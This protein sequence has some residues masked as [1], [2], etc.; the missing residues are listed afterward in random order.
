MFMGSLGVDGDSAMFGSS[1]KAIAG[2]YSVGEVVGDM[3]GNL[4]RDCVAFGRVAAKA[5]CKWMF[6]AAGSG[7]LEHG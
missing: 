1:G 3:H 2:F 4:L 6:G 7:L 5:A